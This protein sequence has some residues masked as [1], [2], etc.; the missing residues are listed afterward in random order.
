MIKNKSVLSIITARGGSK[1]VPKKNIKLLAGKPLIAWTIEAS[2][3]SKYIDKTI[4]ST[5][6]KEIAKISKNNGANV[7]F[8]RPKNLATDT[9]KQEDA[10]IHAMNFLKVNDKKY[11]IIVVLV[12]TTPLRTSKEIDACINQLHVNE[13]QKS[14]FT[15]RECDHTP[16]QANVLPENN[17]MKNF[18]PQK[19]KWL[20]RQ[21]MPVYYQ[22]SG[23]VCVSEWDVFI[24]EKTLVLTDF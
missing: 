3:N 20:N 18:V 17:S 22:L 10:I 19:Y 5:D 24:K 2:L 16:L 21:E 1:G 14:I 12:P 8:L 13:E 23:S 7:P 9:A 11:D 6:N 15:V 4:V